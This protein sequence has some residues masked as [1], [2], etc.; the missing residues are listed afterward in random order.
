M[1]LLLLLPF[2]PRLDAA[3]GGGRVIA[4]FLTGVMKRHRVALVCFREAGEP[5]TDP[6]FRE[7][8]EL[9]E[10]IVRPASEKSGAARL[11][12]YLR[13]MSALVRLRPLWVADWDSPAFAR[14]V[15]EAA[16]GFQPDVIQA[17]YHI[18]GQYLSVLEDIE[19]R[20]MLIEYEPGT[21]AAGYIRTLPPFLN[22]L[23]N[24]IDGISWRRYERWLYRRVGAIVVFTEADRRS[25]KEAA[26][27]T[28][29]YVIPPGMAIPEHPLNPLG[30]YPRSLLFVGN[31]V[32]AP[33]VDAARR[34]VQSIF[35]AVQGRLP[36]VQ[37]FIVGAHPPAR[38]R[39]LAGENVVITGWV[40]DVTPYLDRAAVFAA[41]MYLGGGMRIKVLEALAAGKAVV[42][43]P[44]AIEGLN[45]A[46]GEV[47]LAGNDAEFAE[48]IV[49]LLKDDEE[50]LSLAGRARAWACDH[51]GQDQANEKYETL[52]KELLES[53]LR[54]NL[55]DKASVIQSGL[56]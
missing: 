37:L 52:Y 35:P 24:R 3:H 23:L 33:N 25:I 1:R 38:L 18:M 4:Q 50:R 27:R 16:Q 34:L 44:L 46:D 42:T 29:I 21:R 15:R 13:W 45:L 8:C 32:H 2:A 14:K 30:S 31:F 40:P 11:L 36:E 19:A 12:R 48:R 9:V 28:P 41:P 26:G 22:G 53:P 43:T 7:R 10:E 47:V 39:E 5:G 55:R 49:R 6:F 20:R 51:L 54:S 56:F 17:E